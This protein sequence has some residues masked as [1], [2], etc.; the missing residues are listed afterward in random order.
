MI[1]KPATVMH[2]HAHKHK[3]DYFQ[4]IF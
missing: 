4:A 2:L 1:K 3:R